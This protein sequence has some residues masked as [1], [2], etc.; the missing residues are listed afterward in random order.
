MGTYNR[1]YPD[2]DEFGDDTVT[3]KIRKLEDLGV[4]D[5]P[6]DAP[7]DDS[8]GTTTIT[9]YPFA[10]TKSGHRIGRLFNWLK[11]N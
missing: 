2:A 6:S 7:K 3:R 5:K 9:T 10:K 8:G 4:L 11:K 1:F